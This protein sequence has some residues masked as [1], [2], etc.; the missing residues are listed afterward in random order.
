MVRA[1][2]HDSALLRYVIIH[3]HQDYVDNTLRSI[4]WLDGAM[5]TLA[6]YTLNFFHPGIWLN[7]A[8]PTTQGSQQEA[9]EE[10]AA[11]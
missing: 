5:V 6:I 4:D 2:Y 10:E 3:F 7:K 9:D 1:S 11:A 8:D